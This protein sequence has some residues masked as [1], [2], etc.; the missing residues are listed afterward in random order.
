MPTVY[1][2]KPP[3]PVRTKE[4][5]KVS[6]VV[7]KSNIIAPKPVEQIKVEPSVAMVKYLFVENIDGHA[8]YFAVMKLLE[9]PNLV[10]KTNIDLLLACLLSQ[11]K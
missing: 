8:I 4:H 9:L 1:I 6:T 3:F 11:S 2:E 10:K 7:C 5:P